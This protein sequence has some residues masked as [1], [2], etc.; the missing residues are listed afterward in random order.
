MS[1]ATIP[2]WSYGNAAWNQVMS[3]ARDMFSRFDLVITDQD[4]GSSVVHLEAVV[5]GG[6]GALNMPCS[7]NG[8]VG[9]VAPQMYTWGSDG[10]P[11]CE[12]V[13]EA[14]AFIFPEAFGGDVQSTCETIAQEVAHAFTLDHEY[15][16]HDPMTYLEWDPATNRSCGPKTFQD[17]DV[18]CGEYQ[19]RS[20]C[21]CG[22]ATQNSVKVLY[23]VLGPAREDPIAPQV[24]ITSPSNGAVL[25]PGFAVK[26][27]ATDNIGVLKVEFYIDGS[28]MSTD[29]SS[30]YE[31]TTSTRLADGKHAIMAKAYDA[32]GNSG[33]AEIS[34]TVKAPPRPQPECTTND[35]CGDGMRCDNERCVE[36]GIKP[37]PGNPG[38]F[39][40]TCER[41]E[42]CASGLCAQGGNK[43][44]CTEYC[45]P[46][47][48]SCP[49]G[50]ECM[51]AGNGVSV[52][53]PSGPGGNVVPTP[54][55][56]GGCQVGSR[57][58]ASG[59]WVLLMLVGVVLAVT[60]R[61]GHCS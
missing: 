34:V 23:E 60:R 7:S 21:R 22:G 26:A 45:S 28:L 16:C 18:Q 53:W 32:K 25:E 47:G 50:T 9:G 5:G 6:P 44:V 59:S 41:N 14:I 54:A 57:A 12:V 13:E 61:R 56:S 48:E 42:D 20:R 55:L 35:Q 27:N 19:P 11:Q 10:Q 17:K 33:Q 58:P 1:S 30:P 37:N 36:D 31:F 39:G 8:C 24:S 38:A 43:S 52:C 40:A 4:P 3:C 2:A 46:G 15:D 51:G 49:Q 29:G